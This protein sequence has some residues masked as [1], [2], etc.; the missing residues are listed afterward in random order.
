MIQ[1]QLKEKNLDYLKKFEEL[2]VNDQ[3]EEKKEVEPKEM[4]KP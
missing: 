2:N 1:Q 3:E 4:I